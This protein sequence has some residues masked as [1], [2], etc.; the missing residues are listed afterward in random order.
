MLLN[1]ICCDVLFICKFVVLVL[2]F[3]KSKVVNIVNS[4]VFII[5]FLVVYVKLLYCYFGEIVKL[6]LC[7][8]LEYERY[9]EFL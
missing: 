9:S 4:Y 3:I 5:V 2:Y 8:F 6:I 1:K 7:Y